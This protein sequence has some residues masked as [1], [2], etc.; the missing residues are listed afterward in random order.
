MQKSERER[1]RER[2]REGERAKNRVTKRDVSDGQTNE[3]TNG[4]RGMGMEKKPNKSGGHNWD[5]WRDEAR[6][7][8][9]Q[10]SRQPG[11]WVWVRSGESSRGEKGGDEHRRTRLAKPR[12]NY[13]SPRL[14]CV[15]LSL[16]L[17]HSCCAASARAHHLLFV[18]GTR[19][20]AVSTQR[21]S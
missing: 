3:Q 1:G 14:V 9:R 15:Y 20:R 11:E 2:K 10:A 7:A 12:R 13:Y 6:E 5:E 4:K 16:S 21:G 8:D 19:A 18:S 17:S